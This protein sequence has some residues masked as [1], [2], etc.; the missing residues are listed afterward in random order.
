MSTRGR[1]SIWFLY[2]KTAPRLPGRGCGLVVW[3]YALCCPV[4]GI[5]PSFVRQNRPNSPDTLLIDTY[6]SMATALIERVEPM[7][8]F[9][10]PPNAVTESSDLGCYSRVTDNLSFSSPGINRARRRATSP[11][12][13]GFVRPDG[14]ADGW[15]QLVV[16]WCRLSRLAL[17]SIAV[18]VPAVIAALPLPRLR[19]CPGTR[20]A[21]SG[22]IPF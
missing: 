16:A 17:W 6:P 3:S 19:I 4:L 18:N 13:T 2:K 21:F 8:G 12:Q 7:Q 9:A 5:C 22:G 10:T 20:V 15:V 1:I 14:Q 11:W